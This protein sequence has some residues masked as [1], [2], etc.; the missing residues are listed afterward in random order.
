NF[1]GIL[2]DI[3]IYNRVLTLQEIQE[4]Y[5]GSTPL[6]DPVTNELPTTT[7]L[8]PNYP[9]P[10]NPA[11]AIRYQLSPAGQGASNNV[12]LTIYNLLGQKVRTLVKAR[13]SAGSYQVEWHG[14]DDFGRSVSSGIYIYRL[15]VGDY[16]KS[17]Q[18]VLLR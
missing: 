8:Y 1:K 16:V 13:Q 10:F 15:R 7:L 14:R 11:T 12:E 18:M 4:L 2:D 17:R 6:D 3:R 5:Q 9:N